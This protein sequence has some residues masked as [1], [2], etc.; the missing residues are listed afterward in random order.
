MKKFYTLIG[1]MACASSAL[2]AQESQTIE[3]P[4]IKT[5]TEEID[6]V[7]IDVSSDDAE[8]ED[9]VIDALNDDDLDAGWKSDPEDLVVV[10]VGLRF[11]NIEIPRKSTIE[12]AYVVVT[13][14]EAKT[15]SD[16][17]ELTITGND[18]DNAETFT[19]SA[20]ITDRVKTDASVDWTVAE[21]WGLWTE[22]K[23]VDISSIIQEIVDRDGWKSGNAFALI[24]EGKDQGATGFDNT[25]EMEAFENIADPEEGG[26]GKN[27]SDRVP[28][29]VVKFNT[30]TAVPNTA[31]AIEDE[32]FAPIANPVSDNV[33]LS[34]NESA[35][36]ISIANILGAEVLRTTA[37]CN[38]SINLSALEAGTYFISVELNG[39]IQTQTII[40]Q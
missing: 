7:T 11:Q 5:G 18:V 16:V 22:E 8:Q 28:K 23:T 40:K 39:N 20:L 27:H 6:G 32:L 4:I 3:V 19:E 36:I 30:S 10:T 37:S 26:D 33:S 38:T 1:A 12:E 2:F 34:L 14:H 31:T 17:A 29:L 35:A 21:D 25:R 13:S 9:N 15:A 24:I